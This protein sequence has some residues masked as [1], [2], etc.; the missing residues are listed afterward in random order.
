ML[1]SQLMLVMDGTFVAVRMFGPGARHS[2]AHE[3]AGAAKVLIEEH[4]LAAPITERRIN[5]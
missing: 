2:P 1:A 4:M 3:A 5:S